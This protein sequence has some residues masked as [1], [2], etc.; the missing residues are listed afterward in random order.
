MNQLIKKVLLANSSQ[1]GFNEIY[2]RKFLFNYSRTNQMLMTD[3]NSRHYKY[4][5]PSYNNYPNSKKGE[6]SFQGQ[7]LFWLDEAINTRFN[8]SGQDYKNL[9][10][11]KL[12]PGG[13]YQGYVEDFGKKL[14]FSELTKDL[15][16]DF[17]YQI[18]DDQLVGFIPYIIAKAYNLTNEYAYKLASILTKNNDYI[19]FYEIFDI[20]IKEKNKEKA[21]EAIMPLIPKPYINSITSAISYND[22][23]FIKSIKMLSCA[24]G[25]AIPIIIYLYKKHR[26]LINALSENIILGGA[27]SD[28]AMLLTLL[29]PNDLLPKEWNKYLNT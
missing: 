7:I 11:K 2:N 29:Y 3:N 24:I 14:V 22:N 28:R 8:F 27:S 6:L 20:L 10:L 26:R 21:I 16:V 13:T 4:N 25:Y 15:K 17:K 9:L 5:K 12:M 19:I 23:S 1:L 18:D